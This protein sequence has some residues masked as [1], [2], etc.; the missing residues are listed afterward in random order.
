M[1]ISPIIANSE[2]IL[3]AC[4]LSLIEAYKTIT[5][6]YKNNNISSD[7][8]LASQT[9]YVPQVGLPQ[10]M[11]VTNAIIVKRAPIGAHWILII[12]IILIFHTNAI[13]PVIAIII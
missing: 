11:P 8:S 4:L 1:L 5:P 12:S 3:T 9:Q 13:K 2:V 6:I 10:T 7:V